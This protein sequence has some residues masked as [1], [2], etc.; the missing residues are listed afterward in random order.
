MK[1]GVEVPAGF[2]AVKRKLTVSPTILPLILYSP[3]PPTP[4]DVPKDSKANSS[5]LFKTVEKDYI[6]RN[7]Y[8]K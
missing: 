5:G 6:G 1:I 7:V 4:K 8:D 3:L 2:A